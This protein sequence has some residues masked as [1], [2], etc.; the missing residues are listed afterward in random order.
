MAKRIKIEK[1]DGKLYWGAQSA[2][3]GKDDMYIYSPA[4]KV[5]YI[6]SDRNTVKPYGA[7]KLDNESWHYNHRI[8]TKVLQI[9]GY[10]HI[11]YCD[12][13]QADREEFYQAKLL[14]NG[15]CTDVVA[16]YRRNTCGDALS[17]SEETATEDGQKEK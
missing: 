2:P 8:I 1:K 7:K 12:E 17:F 5:M 11:V 14:P 4:E 13:R 9:N 3:I 10:A 6:I 16:L 15:Y